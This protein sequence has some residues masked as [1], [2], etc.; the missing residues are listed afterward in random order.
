MYLGAVL[1][2][3]VPE[4]NGRHLAGFTVFISQKRSAQPDAAGGQ[5]G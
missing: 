1:T 4:G 2:A 3:T 5:P